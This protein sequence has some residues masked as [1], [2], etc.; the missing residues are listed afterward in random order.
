MKSSMFFEFMN[1]GNTIK[2]IEIYD[3]IDAKDLIYTKDVIIKDCVFNE[4]VRF[5]DCKFLKSVTF[6]N[7]KFGKEFQFI[8]SEC[9]GK[10]QLVSCIFNEDILFN[11]I[12]FAEFSI[13]SSCFQKVIFRGFLKNKS[14]KD[15]AVEF[16]KS[17]L[18]ELVFADLTC[19]KTIKLV[20]IHLETVSFSKCI[21]NSR[22]HFGTKPELSFCANYVFIE[23]SKFSQNVIFDC[24]KIE[25]NLTIQQVEFE[26]VVLICKDF[27][28]EHIILTEI[29]AKN[30][31]CIDFCDNINFLDISNCSFDTCFQIYNLS[32]I[33]SYKKS[34]LINF[35]GIIYGNYVFEDFPAS[36]IDISCV[37][38]GTIIFLNVDT[39]LIILD[40]FFNYGRLFFNSIKYNQ[41]FNALI[42]FDSNIGNTEF[43]N[44]DFRKFNEVVI[45]KSEVSNL[46]LSNSI[47]PNKIQIKTKEP[48][49]GYEVNL[50]GKINDNLYFRDS[51]RQLKIAM[52]KMGNVHSSLIY[53]SK[54]MYYQR[55][56][57]KC[58]LDKLLLYFN[59]IS[60]NNGIS[61]SRG[62]G[63]TL[64][65]G[66]VFFVLL[67]TQMNVPDFH[68]NN[69]VSY[70]SNFLKRYVSYIS[71]YPKLKPANINDN[72]KVDV[73]VL[74][75]RIFISVGIYQTITAFRKYKNK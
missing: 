26:C 47:F 38:F 44:I 54:E 75:S 60:N 1:S 17:N 16:S 25:N 13:L 40:N 37:N 3:S 42:I 66:L 50:D 21:F 70:I 15:D 35:S 10:F 62:I 69:F 58:D 18:E 20:D 11:D 4:S 19:E 12:Y 41:N 2:N 5:T 24:G 46:L 14:F 23:F 71:S 72:W 29:C 39:K 61:W 36:P 56:L 49:L 55:K 34:V 64:I 32:K 31:F 45:A 57:L 22:I 59:Y 73:I 63:F 53:K 51:Y 7:C 8:D 67:N 43:E 48:Q 68:W 28:I 65:C 6:E 74:L 52:E 27:N 33:E 9:S 30:R